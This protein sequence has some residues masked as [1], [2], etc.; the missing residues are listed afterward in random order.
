M[1]ELVFI[2]CLKVNPTACEQRVLSFLNE[3]SGPGACMMRAQPELAA[4]A[5]AHPAFTVENWKCEDS[6]H[7]KVDI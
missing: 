4:W 1:I 5:V 6:D 2:V 3:N 7:A